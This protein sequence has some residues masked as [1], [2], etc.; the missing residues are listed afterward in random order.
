MQMLW[1]QSAT[2]SP[3]QFR[4]AVRRTVGYLTLEAMQIKIKA[5]DRIEVESPKI[6]IDASDSMKITS[7]GDMTLK[8]SVVNI[9]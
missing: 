8:G 7:S 9:N 1:A 3:E 6:D 5:G 4:L 2:R